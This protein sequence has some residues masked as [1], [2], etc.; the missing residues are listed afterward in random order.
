M[1]LGLVQEHLA[2]PPGQAGAVGQGVVQADIDGVVD[3]VLQPVLVP[4]DGL[5]QVDDLLD[6]LGVGELQPREPAAVIGIAALQG[7]AD[8]GHLSGLGGAGL[9]AEGVQEAHQ[10]QGGHG[11]RHGQ[12]AL[13]GSQHPEGLFQQH[14]RH[15]EAHRCP[16]QG[17]Q[18]QGQGVLI[19][20]EEQGGEQAQGQPGA[21]GHADLEQGADQGDG[22]HV[23]GGLHLAAPV[24]QQGQHRQHHPRPGIDGHQQGVVDGPAVGVIDVAVGID[25]GV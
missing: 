25:K 22:H 16:D 7:Q 20:A 19:A 23:S 13:P 14:L 18:G 1:L 12:A 9:D 17:T 2:V 15:E 3:V 5:V 4:D 8:G 21:E 6:V 24:D 10:A 11:R